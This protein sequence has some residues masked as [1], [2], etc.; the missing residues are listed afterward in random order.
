LQPADGKYGYTDG[1][2]HNM[3]TKGKKNFRS[4]MYEFAKTC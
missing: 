2:I 1:Q 4:R 3:L